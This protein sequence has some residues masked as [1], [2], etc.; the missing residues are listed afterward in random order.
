VGDPLKKQQQALIGKMTNWQRT[1]WAKD[2][3]SKDLKIIE[4]F[5]KMKR[6]SK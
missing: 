6:P 4:K 3:Y 2:G 1:Q 5:A